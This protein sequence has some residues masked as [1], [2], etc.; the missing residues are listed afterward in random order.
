MP[1]LLAPEATALSIAITA[2]DCELMPGY[3]PPADVKYRID[4]EGIGVAEGELV[5]GRATVELPGYQLGAV[6]RW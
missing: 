2:T 6:G 4:V 5:G 1:P 3:S